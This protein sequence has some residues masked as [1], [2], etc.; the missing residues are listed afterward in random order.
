MYYNVALGDAKIFYFLL[1]K[2]FNAGTWWGYPNPSGTGMRFNFSS[3][4]GMGRVTGKYMRIGFRDGEGK[5]SPHPAPLSCLLK[6]RV[7]ASPY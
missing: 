6:S 4:L 2:L 5:T 1:K 7:F 3:S